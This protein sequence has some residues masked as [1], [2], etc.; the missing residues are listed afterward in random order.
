[1]PDYKLDKGGMIHFC[2]P[3]K[4]ADSL[5]V[6]DVENLPA[7]RALDFLKEYIDP[8]TNEAKYVNQLV[9][10]GPSGKFVTQGCISPSL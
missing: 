4:T 9:G 7:E 5:E 10:T 8:E 6:S 3:Q 1:M 2:L